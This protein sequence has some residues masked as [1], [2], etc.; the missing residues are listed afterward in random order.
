MN[1]ESKHL[2][3]Y[4]LMDK[5]L[6]NAYNNFCLDT[7]VVIKRTHKNLKNLSLEE[8]IKI[9]IRIYN[10]AKKLNNVK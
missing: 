7:K 4:L 10:D 8:L 2:T 3:P 5:T 6:I 9:M 1:L